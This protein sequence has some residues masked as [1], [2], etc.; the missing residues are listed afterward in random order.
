M[1]K[2]LTTV[3]GATG[4]ASNL[5]GIL[6]R[7]LSSSDNTSAGTAT[8]ATTGNSATSAAAQINFSYLNNALATHNAN[9]VGEFIGQFIFKLIA[10]EI[11]VY[12][13]ETKN[14]YPY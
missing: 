12:K 7:S 14:P 13:E 1:G 5:A 10:V 3:T 2:Q 9:A 11:P 6:L 8:P 4:F